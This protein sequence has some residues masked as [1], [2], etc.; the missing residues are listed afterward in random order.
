MAIR[1][2]HVLTVVLLLFVATALAAVVF[3]KVREGSSEPA[4]ASGIGT[5]SIRK[6]PLPCTTAAF[7]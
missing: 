3:K 7:M 5:S 6:S 2:K 1:P 4:G